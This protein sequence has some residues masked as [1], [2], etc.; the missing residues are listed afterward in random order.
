[1]RE[2]GYWYRVS[3]DRSPTEVYEVL[4]GIELFPKD[5][6]WWFGWNATK[7]VLPARWES[8]EVLEEQWDHFRLFSGQAE[9]RMTRRGGKPTV[10]ILTERGDLAGR[11][12]DFWVG[13]PETFEVK[14]GR[15]VLAGRKMRL[16]G[17][18]NGIR[19]E[20]VY[21]R[22]LVYGI[23]QDVPEKAVVAEVRSYWRNGL[24]FAD[25]YCGI[26]LVEPGSIR[27]DQERGGK[28]EEG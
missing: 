3:G 25:R 14:R 2:R 1:M 19:G 24:R 27:L 17:E 20:V 15:R 5:R 22:A 6:T 28:A 23:A 7:C 8:L 12:R 11:L 10:A 13:E 26:E 16:R 18:E 4:V 21:P 9:L